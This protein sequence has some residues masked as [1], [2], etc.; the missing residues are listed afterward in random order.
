MERSKQQLLE[1][2]NAGPDFN[3]IRPCLIIMRGPN[4]NF[5]TLMYKNFHKFSATTACILP[6]L[7]YVFLNSKTLCIPENVVWTKWTFKCRNT[8]Q[9]GPMQ[10]RKCRDAVQHSLASGGSALCVLPGGLNSLNM[11]QCIPGWMELKMIETGW[12]TEV[13]GTR[14]R[15]RPKKT[16]WDCVK[17]GYGDWRLLTCPA[18]TLRI[19]MCWDW[20]PGDLAN[21]DFPE[22]SVEMIM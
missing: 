16:W 8:P 11:S 9:R 6:D 4:V 7:R 1:M 2:L 19:G 17:S 18:S 3:P 5:L 15:R 10:A 21:P 20:K 14:Q 22:K 12:S 13:E